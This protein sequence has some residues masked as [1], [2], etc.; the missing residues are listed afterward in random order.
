MITP[1][2][3]QVGLS[4]AKLK[5][6]GL[7]RHPLVIFTS[8]NGPCEEGGRLCPY[9]PDLINGEFV[10][11]YQRNFQKPVRFRLADELKKGKH[12][13]RMEKLFSN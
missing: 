8:D 3:A 2:D 1:L 10:V 9:A 13:L 11:F 6:L 5:A 7:E 4:L 12:S